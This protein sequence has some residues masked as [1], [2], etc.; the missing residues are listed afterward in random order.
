MKFD[1]IPYKF[2][3]N[4]KFNM[5]REE[6]RKILGEP[7]STF[8]RNEFS[9]SQSDSYDDY[10]FFVE[11][12]KNDK[13]NAFEG[14]EGSKIMY[15]GKVLMEH[16]YEELYEDF[17]NIDEHLEVDEEG[18]T[19]YKCGISI[20]APDKEEEPNKPCESILIF[21]KDYFEE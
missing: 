17:I 2:V 18:F 15:Q 9:E 20:W 8:K 21:R 6:V 12:D 11:Y 3:G 14:W 13:C 1:I 16:S 7:S 4:I 19:S 10:C 5:S